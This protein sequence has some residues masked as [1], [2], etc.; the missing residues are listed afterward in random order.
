MSERYFSLV[1]LM[2][3]LSHGFFQTLLHFPP[4]FAVHDHIT[5]RPISRLSSHPMSR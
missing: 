4:L 3:S 1:E 2:C 5:N